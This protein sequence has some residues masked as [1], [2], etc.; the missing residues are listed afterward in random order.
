MKA[1]GM[2]ATARWPT[3]TVGIAT[4]ATIGITTTITSKIRAAGTDDESGANSAS[5]QNFTAGD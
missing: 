2:A 3:T 1:T 4:A 5:L